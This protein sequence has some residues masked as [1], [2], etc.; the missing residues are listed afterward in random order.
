MIQTSH[1]SN[2]GS[3]FFIILIAIAMFAGLSFAIIQGGRQSAGD[4]TAEQAKLAAQEVINYGDVIQ[5]A[6]QTLRLRGCS[7][8]E[9]SF[10]DPNQN[11]K[12]KGGSI[13]IHG[14]PNSPGD[15]SCHVFE[16][17]GGKVQSKLLESGYIDP[18]LVTS[19][20]D[21]D[22]RSFIV[23]MIR[24]QGAG[25]E[26]WDDAGTDLVLNVGRLTPQVCMAINTILGIANQN[27]DPPLPPIDT[28]DSGLTDYQGTMHGNGGDPLANVPETMGKRAF[29]VGKDTSGETYT[30]YQLL[31]AR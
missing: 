26:Q 20:T 11:S 6:V 7:L 13:F 17:N 4:L 14:N 30:F 19:S 9:I 21:M 15:K 28:F 24:V 25:N 18:D 27:V 3:A 31:V 8:E 23:T 10:E 5:K 16:P 2:A 12:Q 22:S 29:C 1:S